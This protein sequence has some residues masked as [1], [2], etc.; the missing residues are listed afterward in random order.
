MSKLLCLIVLVT[1]AICKQYPYN[2]R[3]YFFT[4]DN[5]LISAPSLG[6]LSACTPA[7]NST[8]NT[9]ASNS[10]D[11]S[12]STSTSNSTGSSNSTCIAA[13]A[14]ANSTAVTATSNITNSTN[15]TAVNN[16]VTGVSLYI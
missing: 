8:N 10:T 5:D 13:N 3:Y 14:T 6:V 7:T 15:V 16:W 12:N 11:S 2:K 4:V 9:S 1:M